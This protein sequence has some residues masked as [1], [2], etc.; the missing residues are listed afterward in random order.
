M[1]TLKQRMEFAENN[2]TEKGGKPWSAKG[3]PWVVDEL[4]RPVDGFKR[5]PR[6]PTKLCEKCSAMVGDIV[7]HQDDV[8]PRCRRRGMES[9][10][11]AGL[12]AEPC[13]MTVLC[14]P[15]RSG[16]TFNTAAWCLSQLFQERRKRIAFIASSE[17]QMKSIFRENYVDV[18]ARNPGMSKNSE[19]RASQGIIRV[20]RTQSM[21]EGMSTSHKGVT[22]RGRTT[23]VCDEARDVDARTISAILPSIFEQSGF[24]CPNGHLHTSSGEVAPKRCPACNAKLRKWFGRILIMSSAGILDGNPE[25]DW[26]CELV[27]HLRANPS[28]NVH[29]FEANTT[30]NPDIS[31]EITGTVES[32][33]GALESTRQ[34]VS[35]EIENRFTRKGET[36]LSK[37]QIDACV[38]NG[39]RNR[40]KSELE[41]VAFL[42]T[43]R[44]QDLTSLVVLSHDVNNSIDPWSQVVVERIDIWNPKEQPGQVINPATILEHLDLYIPMYPNLR[45]LRVDTRVM[46]WAMALVAKIKKE[47]PW[48]RVVDGY[49]GKRAERQSSWTLLHQRLMAQTIRIPPNKELRAELLSVR[50][51][52]DLQGRLDI[53]DANRNKRHVDVAEGLACCCL[54]AHMESLTTRQS[55]AA[56]QSRLGSSGTRD[57][58][59][60]L[61]KPQV[62]RIDLDKF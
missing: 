12:T 16:K 53:R 32:V 14:L 15:R 35:V 60:S 38:D 2:I 39:L 4:F 61:Y 17:D 44:T 41:C 5:W 7:D 48:G 10:K 21:F 28:P 34:Y 24:N 59:A 46:P 22:G 20:P 49:H 23:V 37:A 42:D 1:A 52:E 40:M 30:V 45:A 57:L 13:I 19:V 58:L 50:R 18:I 47:R 11:C 62:R 29:L 27:N 54:L 51:M 36:L 55:L 31:K 25:R 8:P 9:E 33:F 43:S 3:R 26:F 6:D 56:T